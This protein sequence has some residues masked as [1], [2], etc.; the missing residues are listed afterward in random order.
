MN[1]EDK[2]LVVVV[3]V[4]GELDVTAHPVIAGAIN[5]GLATAVGSIWIDFFSANSCNGCCIS[6][7]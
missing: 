7:I 3:E 6:R 2:Y 4:D 1:T 5:C